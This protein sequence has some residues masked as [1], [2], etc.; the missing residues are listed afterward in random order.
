MADN[1]LFYSPRPRRR[2]DDNAYRGSEASD[3]FDVDL[4]DEPRLNASLRQHRGPAND[5]DLEAGLQGILRRNVNVQMQRRPAVLHLG[6]LLLQDRAEQRAAALRNL[7]NTLQR[8]VQKKTEPQ[9]QKSHALQQ[10]LYCVVQAQTAD[11]QCLLC[12]ETCYAKRM[13]KGSCGHSYC[14]SCLAKHCSA[15]LLGSAK[16]FPRCPDPECLHELTQQELSTVWQ[17]HSCIFI[18]VIAQGC[19]S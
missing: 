10:W 5:A 12:M 7:A 18:V 9:H 11:V 14:V 19:P 6:S 4:F 16:K 1:M 17:V 8:A 13:R 15:Q 2:T 3:F